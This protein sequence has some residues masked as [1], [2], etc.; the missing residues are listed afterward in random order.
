MKFTL[1]W[2]KEHLNVDENHIKIANILTALG[3]E[4]EKVELINPSLKE[5][6]ICEIKKIQKHPNADRLSVC[7]VSVGKKNYS[8]VCGA[9][10]L[11]EGMRTVFAPNKTFIPG[12]NFRLEK[13]SIRGVEGDGM[14][15]SGEELGVSENFEGI[16]DLDKSYQ[17]GT[18]YGESLIDDFLYEIGLTPNRGDCASVKGI[19][20]E[21]GAKI[22]K[23]LNVPSIE[24]NKSKFE[25]K[26]NWDLS[27]LEREQDCP[28]ILGREF[29]IEQNAASPY[30]LKNR[31]TKIGINPH[32]ALVDITNYILF[33]IG[34]PLH[35]FDLDKIEGNLKLRRAES[36]ESFLGLDNKT[37]NLVEKDLVIADDVKIIS[38]AGIMGSL[39]SCVDKNTRKVFLEIA[40]FDPDLI[41]ETGKRHNIL[42]DARYRF[43]RG[44]D[45]NGLKDGMDIATDMIIKYCGGC[46]SKELIAG[47]KIEKNSAIKFRT[48]S[49][50][51]IIG[52]NLEEKKQLEYLRNLG[53]EIEKEENFFIVIAPSWRHDIYHENDLLEEIARLDGYD[54][55]PY[56]NLTKENKMLNSFIPTSTNLGIDIR[57]KLAY[58]GL[59]EIKSFTFISPK[60]II[61][62]SS[63]IQELK[64]SNPISSE[65]SVM[66]N[67]LYPNLLDAVSLN[68]SKGM[69]SFLIFEIGDIFKGTDYH[70]QEKHVSIVLSGYNRKKTWHNNRRH[71]DFFDIEVFFKMILYLL[72]CHHPT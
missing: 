43:E 49:Y 71:F 72:L 11:Y 33:D 3:L 69:D 44:I 47:K 40:Y 60:K 42:T 9:G 24:Y 12:K 67:S 20:R 28:L 15:C 25:S 45:K 13:K 37:Y 61:P 14:L 50:R 23:S 5:M 56:E 68:Y 18:S 34:R 21:L 41:S 66:R 65:L 19:A 6:L 32:S 62:E 46:F 36:N 70:N 57:E 59:N 2:L 39:N 51:N 10:N 29:H 16:I 53:F 22:S 52:Y 4:V 35:V 26:K 38:L 54:K 31:L 58:S 64:I 7:E 30:F 48:S 27:N 1:S 63:D 8:V 55:I 17:L